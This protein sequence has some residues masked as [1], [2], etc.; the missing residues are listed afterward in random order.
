MGLTNN[1]N[2]LQTLVNAGSDALNNLYEVSFVGGHLTQVNNNLKVRCTGF[3]PPQVSQDSYT[4]RFVNTYI[5]R[6][7]AK[8]NVIRNFTISF[9]VDANFEVYKALLEQERVTFN[10]TQSYTATDIQAIKD[11][12]D[13]FDVTVSIVNQGINS[14]IIDTKTI[15]SFHNCW[16]TSIPS[17]QYNTDNSGPATIQI[18]ISFLEMEDWQSGITGYSNPI[19][20]G[21]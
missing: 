15:Y 3:T 16:I 13:L 11:R 8:V 6:P 17:I 5:D 1:N 4:V 20:L 10:P 9:R 12:G 14:E 19:I 21:Y 7:N 18:G 2:Y